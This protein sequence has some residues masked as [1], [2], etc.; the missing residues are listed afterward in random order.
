LFD[1]KRYNY[2]HPSHQT[3]IDGVSTAVS[4]QPNLVQYRLLQRCALWLHLE[5]QRVQNN[6]ACA[7]GIEAFP[8]QSV[9]APA[10]LA[11]SS[12]ADHIQVGSSDVS[13]QS[14]EHVH[15]EL[16]V[17]QDHGTCL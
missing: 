7:P 2:G 17:L 16:T 15:S 13:L 3:P 11:V 8:C 9:A 10:T 1:T 12:A 5:L 14:S 4:M 6:A